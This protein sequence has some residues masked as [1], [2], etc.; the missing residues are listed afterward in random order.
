MTTERPPLT[1]TE[2]TKV[3]RIGR[4]TLKKLLAAGKFP[5]AYKTSERGHWRIPETAITAYIAQRQ[6]N[7]Q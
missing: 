3:L 7:Q 5:S 1:L 2:A 6:E 4:S